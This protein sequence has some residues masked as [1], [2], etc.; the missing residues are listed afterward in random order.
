M[1]E[2]PSPPDLLESAPRYRIDRAAT[3]R[4][5]VFAFAGSTSGGLFSAAL[6]RA[7]LPHSS[8]DPRG[9]AADLFLERFV[10]EQMAPEDRKSVV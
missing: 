7:V 5:L 3:D 9:Y 4:D 2:V 6:E 8:W 10:R 1:D